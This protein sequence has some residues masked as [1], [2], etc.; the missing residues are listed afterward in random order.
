M[1]K[2]FHD[3]S[4][5][6]MGINNNETAQPPMPCSS[7][8]SLMLRQFATHLETNVPRRYTKHEQSQ[9]RHPASQYGSCE[10]SL[11][12]PVSRLMPQ[13]EIAFYALS[14]RDSNTPSRNLSL[15]LSLNCLP[16][17]QTTK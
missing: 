13:D 2:L 10:P 1:C 4:R 14:F 3:G 17:P 16:H 12:K 9:L 6:I 7:I 11:L 5:S 8:A 15:P